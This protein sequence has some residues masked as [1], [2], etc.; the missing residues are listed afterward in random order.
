MHRVLEAW[1]LVW[2]KSINVA[3]SAAGVTPKVFANF[4]PGLSYGNLG[5]NECH[6]VGTPNPKR[7]APAA[8]KPVAIPSGL[9]QKQSPVFIL[10]VAKARPLG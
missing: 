3:N 5:I 8:R 10:R 2:R 1:L 7:V 6:L 4:G 9:R